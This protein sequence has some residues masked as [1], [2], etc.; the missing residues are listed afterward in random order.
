[1]H[2]YGPQ[3]DRIITKALKLL[4]T[5]D[6]TTT[7]TVVDFYDR[8]Q[9]SASGLVIAIL[10]FDAIMLS[11]GFEGLCVPTL[12][13]YCYQL[14]SKVLMELLPCLIPGGLSPEI[15]AVLASVWYKS[16]NGYGYLWRVLEL[17][18]PGFDPV[19]PIQTP[20]WSNADDILR[21]AQAYLLHF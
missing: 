12:G 9:K 11:N 7:D 8:L 2:T 3:V 1:L 19:V 6:S 14:M 17:T 18:M 16:N 15:N 4:P 10:P 21:F 13:V 20:S 5:L